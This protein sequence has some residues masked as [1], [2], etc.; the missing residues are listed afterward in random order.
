MEPLRPPRPLLAVGAP[1]RPSR[2]LLAAEP[3]RRPP[4]FLVPAA[5][6]SRASSGEDE[7]RYNA[8]WVIFVAWEH[9]PLVVASQTN[10]EAVCKQS[11]D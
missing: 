9:E 3:P 6:S 4:P 8:S 5:G 2:P 1:W 10:E 11:G 7:E